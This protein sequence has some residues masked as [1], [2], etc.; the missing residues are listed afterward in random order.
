V[1]V[2][3]PVFEPDKLFLYTGRDFKWAYEL[4]DRAG[5][6]VDFPPGR[7]YFLFCTCPD[8]TVWDFVIEGAVATIK[9]EHEVA[10]LIPNRTKF[11][12]VFL[13]EGE[14]AGGD[15]ITLGTVSRQGC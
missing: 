5:V 8:E 9:V 3:G 7:L 15:P 13:H 4:V 10:D 11:Q 14:A 6:P 2:I 1:A 12:L